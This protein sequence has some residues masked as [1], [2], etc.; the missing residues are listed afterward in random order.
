MADGVVSSNPNQPYSPSAGGYVSSGSVSNP[1]TQYSTERYRNPTTPLRQRSQLP[2]PQ[3]GSAG[4]VYLT[5][6][7][8]KSTPLDRYIPVQDAYNM[9]SSLSPDAIKKFDSTMDKY[10]GKGKWEPSWRSGL[11]NKSV[12]AASYALTYNGQRLSPLDA[13][14]SVL[15]S[16]TGGSGAGV[17][18]GSGSGGGGYSGPVTSRQTSTNINLTDPTTARGLVDK[19]LSSYL[20]REANVK[21]QAAFRKALNIQEKM[22]P[23]VTQQTSVTTPGVGTSDTVSQSQTQGG[24]NPSVFAE[25]YARGQEGSAEFQAATTMLDTF[26][27]SLKARV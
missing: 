14:D 9:L 21:E 16:E 5:T 1:Y 11:W 25:E 12:G 22:N 7:G 2:P 23:S 8:S 15:A 19:A 24:F 27:G 4:M 17:G 18:G 10:Y 13:L 20:G 3:P 26:I 6:T